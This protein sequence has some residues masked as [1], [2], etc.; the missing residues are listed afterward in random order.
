MPS[1]FPGAA[2]NIEND[3][4]NSTLQ[5]DVHPLLHNQLA[6]AVNAI[7]QVLLSGNAV[8]L[9]GLELGG[10]LT[11]SND[12]T[13]DVGDSTGARPRDVYVGS[14]VIFGDPALFN[15]TAMTQEDGVTELA[16]EDGATTLSPEEFGILALSQG[17]L[18]QQIRLYATTDVGPV[19]FKRLLVS[20]I[21][22]I[23][24]QAGGTETVENLT[25]GTEGVA[26][27]I[28][29][30]NFTERWQIDP[31]GH[32][33]AF[34]GQTVDIGTSSVPAN[35]PRHV[36]LSGSVGFNGSSTVGRPTITGSRGGNAALTSLLTALNAMGLVTDGTTT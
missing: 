16:E 8:V 19:N 10:P 9:L 5:V 15:G 25:L 34:S 18:A 31:N 29:E 1:N 26:S 3:I 7:Q 20:S 11:F 13:F 36:Y 33:L 17:A 12:N 27:I 24:T 6:D 28:L 30:T 22:D 21:G 32:L 14:R 2:D 35:R 4:L 23:V